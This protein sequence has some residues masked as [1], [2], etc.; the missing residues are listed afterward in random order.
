MSAWQEERGPDAAAQGLL[1]FPG[2]AAVTTQTISDRG[3]GCRPGGRRR[4]H[5]GAGAGAAGPDSL[6]VGAQEPGKPTVAWPEAGPDEGMRYS[7]A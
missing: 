3:E 6:T 7:T 5:P 1:L 2:L 4:R